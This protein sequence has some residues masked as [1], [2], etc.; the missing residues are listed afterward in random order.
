MSY[1]TILLY[2]RHHY[3]VMSNVYATI[4]MI[5]RQL[6]NDFLHNEYLILLETIDRFNPSG[7]NSFAR[8]NENKNEINKIINA[9]I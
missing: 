5:Q 3:P 6:C 8:K 4:R 1:Q 9:H 7:P 2:T